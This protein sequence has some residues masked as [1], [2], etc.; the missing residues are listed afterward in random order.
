MIECYYMK[1]TVLII[2]LLGTYVAIAL[3]YIIVFLH[4]NIQNMKG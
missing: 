2:S 4:K 3:T 1:E